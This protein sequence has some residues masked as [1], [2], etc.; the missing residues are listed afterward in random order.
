[1][2]LESQKDLRLFYLFCRRFKS[3]LHGE[4]S[5]SN[6]FPTMTK[7]V[8]VFNTS[9][10]PDRPI[11]KG[12]TAYHDAVINASWHV[13]NIQELIDTFSKKIKN[14]DLVVDFG[15]G[16][17][18]SAVY[19]LKKI[20]KK[21]DLWLVDNSPSWL[22]KAYDILH[23]K[24]NVDFF[25]LEK[26]QDKYETLNE[27]IGKDIAEH[28]ISANTVHLIPDINRAFKGVY[29]ALK[30]GGA[31]IFQS[32]NIA[33]VNRKKG[34]MMIDNSV[35]E[36]HDIA[37]KIIQTSDEFKKYKKNS[38]KRIRLNLDQ[39]KLVFPDPRFI[40]YY[41]SHLQSAGFKEPS[42][43][44]KSI[45]VFYKDWLS[46]LRVRRLQAGILPEVGGRDTDPATEQE[47]D[48][49]ITMAAHEFFNTLKKTNPFATKSFF[50]AEWTYVSAKK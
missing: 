36:V 24:K 40:E 2:Q 37:V 4:V 41:V 10:K 38:T 27:T 23:T 8:S 6:M 45:K 48:R 13:D 15:A 35:K 30:P 47:R 5:Y 19:F 14:G 26:I 34:L 1:M 32:G 7:K 44:Y 29:K 11:S 17:G 21:F 22:G 9:W 43:T 20:K 18:A 50:T 42:V 12:A 16:T 33:R 31:F 3:Q 39:R 46:F 49:L 25:I 28:V